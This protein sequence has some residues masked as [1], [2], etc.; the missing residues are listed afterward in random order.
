MKFVFYDLNETQVDSLVS[1]LKEEGMFFTVKSEA[2]MIGFFGSC[3]SSYSVS[4]DTYYEKYL[5]LKQLLEQKSKSLQKLEK[6][7]DKPCAK[8]TKTKK[9]TEV[10]TTV[11]KPTRTKRK[12]KASDG[13]SFSIAF[14]STDGGN[15]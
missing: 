1:I 10:K 7:Y 4:I 14:Y 12:T 3:Y 15:D 8:K 13:Y 2:K 11:K 6:S 9:I 5:F